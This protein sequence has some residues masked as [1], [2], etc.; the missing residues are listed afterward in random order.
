MV[1][2]VIICFV[3][4]FW[5]LG[6]SQAALCSLNGK[7]VAV[8]GGDSWQCLNTVEVYD[9]SENKWSYLTPMAT[10]RRGAGVAVFKG[11]LYLYRRSNCLGFS[12]VLR[13]Y[14]SFFPSNDRHLFTDK[15]YVV[16]GSDGT[17]SLAT[18]EIYDPVTQMWSFGPVMS[19]PRANVGVAVVGK[20]L[21]AVGGFSGKAFLESVEYLAEDGS[22][23]CC[24]V[25]LPDSEQKMNNA[26]QRIDINSIEKIP[27]VAN[28]NVD[29]KAIKKPQNTSVAKPVQNNSITSETKQAKA[30]T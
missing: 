15:L 18:V 20:R 19:I 1:K 25:P 27:S 6:R 23:W 11:Q 14:E 22:E 2:R 26:K 9:P 3:P 21:F 5:V 8:G 4:L 10:A 30:S 28:G 29:T 7:L 16:G 13:L 12:S 17:A 24:C